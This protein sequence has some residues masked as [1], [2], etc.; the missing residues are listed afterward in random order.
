MTATLAYY[1]EH[2]AAFFA[3]TVDVDMAALHQRFLST[4]SAG[5]VLLDAGCGSGRDTRAFLERDFRVFAFDASPELAQL[6]AVHTGIAV[7]VRTFS[8]VREQSCYDGIWACASLLHL[9]A[10]D[11]PAALAQLFPRCLAPV[12]IPA[13]GT[14]AMSAWPN[15]R[16]KSCLSR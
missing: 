1:N 14:R 11:I 8:D 3:D 15:R 6:A 12:S 7:A 9:P 2:A 10:A 4:I 13:I 5:G 16:R